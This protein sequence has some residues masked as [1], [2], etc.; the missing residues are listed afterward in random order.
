MATPVTRARSGRRALGRRR[1]GRDPSRRPP[2]S[3]AA[4]CAPGGPP[5]RRKWAA[6]G[7]DTRA[8]GGG[9]RLLHDLPRLQVAAQ[10]EAAGGAEG[11]RHGAAG[12]ARHAHGEAALAL[13]RDAHRLH[14]LPVCR[15]EDELR[16]R[17]KGGGGLVLQLQTRHVYR[18]GQR[19]QADAAHA[20]EDKS[21][22]AAAGAGA[23]A[24][25]CEG[26]R[27]RRR[28]SA[29]RAHEVHDAPSIGAGEG[30]KT[31]LRLWQADRTLRASSTVSGGT[32][33][34]RRSA[35]R[36]CRGRSAAIGVAPLLRVVR[37]V[38]RGAAASDNERPSRAAWQRAVSPRQ[39]EVSASRRTSL[40]YR[41]S[42]RRHSR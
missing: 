25:R 35:V 13:E 7:R 5:K 36:P 27:P 16:K 21:A 11:A 22:A 19:R 9:S 4:P 39:G 29:R 24:R 23:G 3:R 26:G 40:A 12:L 31:C 32:A 33:C 10:T 8:C 18:S 15:G 41:P 37:R 30:S 20:C 38:V 42:R 34:E 2:A 17:V 6:R 28:R 14:R 1:R